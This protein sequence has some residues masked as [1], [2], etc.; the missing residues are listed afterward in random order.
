MIANHVVV[1]VSYIP[2]SRLF[3]AHRE[4]LPSL[5]AGSLPELR[6][7][8]AAAVPPEQKFTL[9]LSRAARAEVARRRSE[10]V[11]VGWTWPATAAG[12]G[13]RYTT[14]RPLRQQFRAG[15]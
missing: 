5:S 11:Q 1:Y 6:A 10:P 8:V 15:S 14:T 4:G 13:V 7:R 9:S 3:T 12:E 2:P